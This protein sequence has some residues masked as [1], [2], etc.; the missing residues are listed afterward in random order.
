[1]NR[2]QRREQRKQPAARIAPANAAVNAQN[3]L[4][5]LRNTDRLSSEAQLDSHLKLHIMF[6]DL[7]QV[8]HDYAVLYM[9][10]VIKHMRTSGKL[11]NRPQYQEWADQAEKEL[12]ESIKGRRHFP[13]LKK[14]VLRLEEEIV[15]TSAHLQLVC[16]D[17][18]AAVG[19]LENAVGII[20]LPDEAE[21][22]L[23]AL[24]DGLSLKTAAQQHNLPETQA[25]A[26]LLDYA[27]YLSNLSAGKLPVCRSVPEVKKHIRALLDIRNEVKEAA[28]DAA[29]SVRQFQHRF[30]VSLIDIREISQMLLQRKAA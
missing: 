24:S 15:G 1:M 19:I 2:A 27:W 25:R 12:N 20:E 7:T 26:M 3:R 29:A 6:Y 13:N 5:L 8:H 4:V 16:N 11:Q 30:G 17:H 28:A 21:A 14:L 23:N 18:A 9:H 22:L 10:H